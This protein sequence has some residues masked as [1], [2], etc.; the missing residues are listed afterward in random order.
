MI[1]IN[2]MSIEVP[3]TTELIEIKVTENI[4]IKSIDAENS[5]MLVVA[6]KIIFEP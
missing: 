4:T 3:G 1:I 6:K 2:L 5:I